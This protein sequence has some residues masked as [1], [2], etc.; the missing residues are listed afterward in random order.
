M[1]WGKVK[2]FFSKMKKN[3]RA[4]AQ[5]IQEVMQFIFT[6]KRAYIYFSFFINKRLNYTLSVIH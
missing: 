2:E 3:R 4:Y 6:G 5:K 1:L